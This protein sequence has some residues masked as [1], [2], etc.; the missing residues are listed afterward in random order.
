MLGKTEVRYLSLFGLSL[1]FSGV[2]LGL[3]IQ[4]YSLTPLYFFLNQCTSFTAYITG[5]QSLFGLALLSI[6][7]GAGSLLVVKVLLSL[8]KTHLKLEAIKRQR[9][10]RTPPAI[11][12][13]CQRFKV[14]TSRIIST[15]QLQP[16]AFTIGFLRPKMVISR[17][18]IK[19]LNPKELEA[20]FLHELYHLQHKHGLVFI[21]GEIVSSALTFILPFL[22]DALKR[23]KL[24]LETS[25][26]RFASQIQHTP[27]HLTQALAKLQHTPTIELYPGFASIVEYRAR[28]LDSQA[29]LITS[30]NKLKLMVSLVVVYSLCYLALS[31]RP[32]QATNI[33]LFNSSSE[34]CQELRSQSEVDQNFSPAFWP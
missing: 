15:T 14:P 33:P 16:L 5:K 10:Q 25:A 1:L 20:V 28:V 17:G 4:K 27:I 29:P 8:A 2:L 34:Q 19:T 11:V 6:C 23:M 32:T 3:C 24:Q 9:Y 12:A 7:L 21:T 26:D 13:I 31:P 22:H 18:L 30:L